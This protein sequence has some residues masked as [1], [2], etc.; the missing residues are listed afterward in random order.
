M[1]VITE[2][3]MMQHMA[4]ALSHDE[5]APK[6]KHVR[7]LII[8][9][10]QGVPNAYATF[11][12]AFKQQNLHTD[13]V[14]CYKG[15]LTLHKVIRDCNVDFLKSAFRE[16][17]FLK[18]LVNQPMRSG[19]RGYQ[20]LIAAYNHF[21][22]LKLAFHQVHPEFSPN[23]SYA[24]YV[25]LRKAHE[26]NEAYQTVLD[27]FK[28]QGDVLILVG[29]VF[30]SFKTGVANECRISSLVPLIEESW[31]IYQF[32]MSML[33]A[34]HAMVS[35]ISVYTELRDKFSEQHA[36]LHK[37]YESSSSIRYL[38]SLIDIPRLSRDPPL[39]YEPHQALPVEPPRKA[40]SPPPPV[41][42]PPPEPIVVHVPSGPDPALLR[43]LAEKDA[44]IAR[45]RNRVAELEHEL[46]VMR[47][48]L[49]GEQTRSMDL[50]SRSKTL[51]EE[52]KAASANL[53]RLTKM[54]GTMR[55]QHLDLLRQKQDFATET[56]RQAAASEAA[57]AEARRNAEA[58]VRKDTEKTIAEELAKA[59][60][61]HEEALQRLKEQEARER[62]LLASQLAQTKLT[63][64]E[65]SK[66][67]GAES[68]ALRQHYA[69]LEEAQAASLAAA[70][71]ESDRLQA[72]LASQRVFYDALKRESD[73]RA[74]ELALQRQENEARMA[75]AERIARADA[76]ALASARRANLQL[77]A[78]RLLEEVRGRV[79]LSVASDTCAPHANASRAI[80]ASDAIRAA[81]ESFN[82]LNTVEFMNSL[83][84]SH[85]GASGAAG[86]TGADG[87]TADLSEL[88]RQAHAVAENI[89]SMLN[90]VR[91]L[92][93]TYEGLFDGAGGTGTGGE[94]PRFD[95][96]ALIRAAEKVAGSCRDMLRRPMETGATTTDNQEHA[97][98][99]EAAMQTLS[100]LLGQL[101]D[102]SAI[103]TTKSLDIDGAMAGAA[104]EIDQAVAR[105]SALLAEAMKEPSRAVHAS[106]LDTTRAIAGAI[107]A[108]MRAA[109][110]AQ[111]EIVAK[112]RGTASPD[113]FYRKNHRW[114][115][116]LVSA[117]QSVA[118][119]T[120]VLV[121]KADRAV[122]DDP[123]A[124]G[125][126]RMEYLVASAHQ[127]AASTAQLVAASRV[128]A[129]RNSV[130]QENLEGAAKVVSEATRALVRAVK[131]ISSRAAAEK[132]ASQPAAAA[133]GQLSSAQFRMQDMEKQVKILSLEKALEDAR[134]EL[135]DLRKLNYHNLE[136]DSPTADSPPETAGG[137]ETSVNK[138]T[139]N[140]AT[141]A[142]GPMSKKVP[143]PVAPKPSFN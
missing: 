33:R 103:S 82:G 75:E 109:R 19:A 18:S 34:M 116:G 110:L 20:R 47:G 83:V 88:L 86:G 59:Q 65:F 40:A 108:L 136:A 36:S 91:G 27:L 78:D 77:L 119:C 143:P 29:I 99:F 107:G 141:P 24:D 43:L 131:Q 53:A 17:N 3:D 67:S 100:G 35:D 87:G 105:L 69:R 66:S 98:G 96:E 93:A 54:Y 138:M 118:S 92:G 60:K 23:M 133:G 25:S 113:Q 112:G 11:W 73:A 13:E 48:L 10:M 97:A 84:L 101:P 74:A 12:N 63:L 58:A 85:D 114:T 122:S 6:P 79:D 52:H 56:R 102:P 39:L 115:E 4:K 139:L 117:A 128:K 45:L 129:D 127:V 72:E 120:N 41:A 32:L 125:E 94:M 81:L 132:A 111:E 76:E 21:L 70:K 2:R 142:P 49:A 26:P 37:F 31:G 5:T 46:G 95:A 28:L 62:E 64:E 22:I 42:S 90:T 38:T 124:D 130:T 51:D 71:L 9:N 50:E 135:A 89:D 106:L 44:E 61:A 15:L 55:A 137:L 123:E 140:A 126:N 14:V 16:V 30:N 8:Y 134:R 57:I 121:D 7:A 80:A 68:D 104:A 1:S